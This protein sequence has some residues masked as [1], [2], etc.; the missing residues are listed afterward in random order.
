MP[1]KK[2]KA[3]RRGAGARKVP[4]GLPCPECDFVARHAMGLG[5][6]RSARHGV[7]PKRATGPRPAPPG[8]AWITREQATQR[9]G[10]HYNTIRHWERRGLVRTTKRAGIRGVFVHGDDIERAALGEHP[11]PGRRGASLEDLEARY[12]ELIT[13]LERLLSAA[14]TAADRVVTRRP[15]GRRRQAGG[16]RVRAKATV[17]RGRGSR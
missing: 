4:G 14:K 15:G 8:G 6:H 10:V 5:R 13:K 7:P 11:G 3:T 12:K 1:A 9:A 17:R 2:R 16:A